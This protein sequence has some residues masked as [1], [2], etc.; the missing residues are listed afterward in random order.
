MKIVKKDICFSPA[1]S[2]FVNRIRKK[3]YAGIHTPN[4]VVRYS[5]PHKKNGCR[6]PG[7][8]F[9]VCRKILIPTWKEPF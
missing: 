2:E 3:A 1:E 9:V 5:G 6:S 7:K 8:F 4:F